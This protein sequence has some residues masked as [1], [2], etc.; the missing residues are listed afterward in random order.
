MLKVHLPEYF[1]KFA[2]NLS[3]KIMNIKY[4]LFLILLFSNRYLLFS[5]NSKAEI[6]FA[7]TEYNFGDLDV[8]NGE[9]ACEFN[10]INKGNL[11]L[12]LSNVRASCGCTTPEWTREPVLPG[13]WGM[14]K[15]VYNPKGNAGSF[16]KSITVSS[17]AGNGDVLLK[18][19]GNVL[20]AT[21]QQDAFKYTIGDVKLTSIHASFGSIVKGSGSKKIIEVKNTSDKPVTLSFSNVPAF[22]K[23]KTDPVSID[24]EKQG[25]IEIEFDSKL[26]GEWD[27]VVKRL[28][29]LINGKSYPN[30]II[31][32]T[33]LIKEDFSGYTT[34]DLNNAPKIVFDST[35][36]NF[37]TIDRKKNIIHEF[38]LT[39]TGKTDLILRK[40][41]ASCGCTVVKPS[42][43]VI[44]PGSSTTIQ[45]NFNPAG[46][47][48]DQNYAI[49]VISNDPKNSKK[50]LRLEGKV[51]E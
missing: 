16:S 20:N 27:Y 9:V 41:S 48:G 12:V 7:T 47:S 24:P 39:N 34:E 28:P 11:P 30:N 15:V 10:F 44:K 17:N 38:R 33:A 40:V 25:I 49:T 3:E 6:E 32:S 21:F 29:L 13:K 1:F 51:T 42:E 19:R 35:I 4:F 36:Y 2:V 43:N 23:I 45:V 8:S 22:I 50:V 46:K 31:S 18:I 26:T 37:G 14:I 5:Q